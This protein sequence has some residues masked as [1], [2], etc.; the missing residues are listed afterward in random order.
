MKHIISLLLIL[1]MTIIGFSQNNDSIPEGIVY[2]KA[3]D[4]INEQAKNIL[5]NELKSP[6]FSLF[7]KLLYCGPNFWEH[8]KNDPKIRSIEKGN[9]DFQVPQPNG[10]TI[11][12][13]GKLIQS[14]DDF[15]IIWNQISKDFYSPNLTIR[16]LNSTELKYYWSIIFFDIEEP[17]YIIE[18]NTIFLIID[19][20][21]TC[22]SIQFIECYYKH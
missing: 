17:I 22:S 9:I 12:K 1:N 11:V 15:K 21:K 10:K 6:S 18:S 19:I 8:Y 5:I 2:K 13:N 3:S 14:I 7:D 4:A 16:K 20:S